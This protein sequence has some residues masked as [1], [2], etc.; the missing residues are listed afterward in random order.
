MYC[1]LVTKHACE[2]DGWTDIITIPKTA[3]AQLLRAVKT[4]ILYE[5]HIYVLCIEI[6]QDG[7]FDDKISKILIQSSS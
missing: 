3:L 4:V 1:S 2:T 6:I 5:I 7:C